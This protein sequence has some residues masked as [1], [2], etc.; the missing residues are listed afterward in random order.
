MGDLAREKRDL[1]RRARRLADTQ[2]QEADKALLHRYADELDQHA[3]TSVYDKSVDVSLDACTPARMRC[4]FSGVRRRLAG[5]VSCDRYLRDK[6][7]AKGRWR[8]R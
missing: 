1:A 5:W 7:D 2:S 4:G 8:G 3:S 6:L